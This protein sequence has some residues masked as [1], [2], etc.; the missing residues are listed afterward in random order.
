MDRMIT[1]R[2]L[3]STTVL[4]LGS[5]TAFVAG[6]RPAGALSLEAMNPETRRLYLSACTARDGTYHRQLVVEVR[7]AL[8]NR[9]SEAEIETAIA[10]ATCPVCGCPITAS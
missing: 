8:Q 5:V 2:H 9:A 3:L 1:R 7:Q 10:G 6:T 4:T